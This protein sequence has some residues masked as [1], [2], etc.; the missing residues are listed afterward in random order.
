MH[1]GARV[2]PDDLLALFDVLAEARQTVEQFRRNQPADARRHNVLMDRHALDVNQAITKLQRD[3]MSI[4][5]THLDQQMRIAN[6][7]R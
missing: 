6:N 3:A 1:N 4:E 7:C 2:G 5:A